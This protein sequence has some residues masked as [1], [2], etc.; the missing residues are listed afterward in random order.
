MDGTIREYCKGWWIWKR[1]FTRLPDKCTYQGMLFLIISFPFCWSSSYHIPS[2]VQGELITFSEP[3]NWT[4]KTEWSEFST[5]SS[6]VA[7]YGCFGRCLQQHVKFVIGMDTWQTDASIDMTFHDGL[8]LLQFLKHK[9]MFI[10]VINKIQISMLTPVLLH[11]WQISRKPNHL[12]I[13]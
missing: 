13:T 6:H 3:P 10:R 1:L 7:I 5:S 2:Q 12:L 4:T 8:R 11:I 9:R